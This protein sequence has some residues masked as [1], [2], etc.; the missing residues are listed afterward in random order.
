MGCISSSSTRMIVV[1]V[2]CIIT[3][4]TTATLALVH[5]IGNHTDTMFICEWHIQSFITKYRHDVFGTATHM[6]TTCFGTRVVV[7]VV[8]DMLRIDCIDRM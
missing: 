4:I 5:N 8:G 2:I 7:V 3:F 6:T 1:V